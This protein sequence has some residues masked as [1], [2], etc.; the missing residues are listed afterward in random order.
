MLKECSLVTRKSQ[1]ITFS[2]LVVSASR[3][4]GLGVARNYFHSVHLRKLTV[5][6]ELNL[7][8]HKSPHVVAKPISVQFLSLEVKLGLDPGSKSVVDRLVKLDQHSQ[9]KSWT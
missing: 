4:R 3:H 8:Q 1:K 5:L 7:L 2:F 6:A 9:S